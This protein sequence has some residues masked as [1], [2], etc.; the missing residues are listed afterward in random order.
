VSPDA[1]SKYPTVSG[2]ECAVTIPSAHKVT[3][4]LAAITTNARSHLSS[5]ATEIRTFEYPLFVYCALPA[6]I[7]SGD[8]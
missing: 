7:K 4:K 8:T 1:L 6:F 2:A 3:T 5:A